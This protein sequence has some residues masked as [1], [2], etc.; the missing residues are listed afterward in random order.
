MTAINMNVS[1]AKQTGRHS[2]DLSTP[3]K[4]FSFTA[5]SSRELVAWLGSLSQAVKSALSCSEVAE[6][7]WGSTWNRNCADCWS[8]DPEWASVNLLVVIC[9]NCA[10]QHRAMGTTVSKVCSLKMGKSMWTEPL[11]QVLK[12]MHRAGQCYAEWKQSNSPNKKPWLHPEQSAPLP[13]LSLS[14][15]DIQRT[16]SLENVD[17]SAVREERESEGEEDN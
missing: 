14:A 13:F 2:F 12:K 11:I 8:P 15:L 4:I 1:Q 3:Y 16:E 9:D 5:D 6:R 7:V 17:E 10:G